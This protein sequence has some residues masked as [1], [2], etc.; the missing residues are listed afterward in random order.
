MESDLDIRRVDLRGVERAGTVRWFKPDKG[1]GRITADDGEVLF[2]HFSDIQAEGYRFL[3]EGQ[4]VTFSWRG[5]LAAQGR[6]HAEQV[7]LLG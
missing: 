2:V 6:H 5:G 1:Y 3:E 4:R 7:R